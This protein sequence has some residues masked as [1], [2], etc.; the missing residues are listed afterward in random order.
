MKQIKCDDIGIGNTIKILNRTNNNY[1]ILIV[2]D[3]L[4][5][6]DE[7]DYNERDLLYI[8]STYIHT[9]II[10]YREDMNRERRFAITDEDDITLYEDYDDVMV[11]LI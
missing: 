2:T 3:L 1:I 4:D 10:D 11:D 8:M 6:E 5:A 7:D 9:N